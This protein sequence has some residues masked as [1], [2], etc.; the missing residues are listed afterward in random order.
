MLHTRRRRDSG[1][2]ICLLDDK[3]GILFGGDTIN[4]GPIYAQF[5]DSDVETFTKDAGASGRAQGRRLHGGGQPLGRTVA[6]PYL[7]QEIADG[8]E[9]ALAGA[10]RGKDVPRLYRRHGP[11]TGL[12]QV[13][14]F[15]RA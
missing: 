8:F 13:L 4:T 9:Q 15:R 5:H 10:G 14:D 2:S 3:S 7:L 1:D 6:A 11:R 12:R